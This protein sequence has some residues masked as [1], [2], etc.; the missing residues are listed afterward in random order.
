[1]FILHKPGNLGAKGTLDHFLM[2]EPEGW[3]PSNAYLDFSAIITEDLYDKIKETSIDKYP[4]IE[5]RRMYLLEY[6]RH[7]KEKL[8][9]DSIYYESCITVE[10]KLSSERSTEDPDYKITDFEDFNQAVTSKLDEKNIPTFLNKHNEL[11]KALQINGIEH[12]RLNSEIQTLF[13]NNGAS[14]IVQPVAI[15][16]HPVLLLNLL[17]P[18]ADV[19]KPKDLKTGT[20]ASLRKWYVRRMLS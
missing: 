16:I 14:D 1:V 17:V 18:L 5:T 11:K 13:G 9:S 20:L 4:D 8:Q 12:S 2:A 19:N 7:L 3:L 15:P 6:I 10:N